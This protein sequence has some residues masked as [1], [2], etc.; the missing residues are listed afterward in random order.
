MNQ[1]KQPTWLSQY[2]KTLRKNMTEAERRLWHHLRSN[3][4]NDA[5]FRRQVPIHHYIADFLCVSAHLV[6]ELDGSQHQQSENRIYDK[7]R[8]LYFESLGYRVLRVSNEEVFNTIVF[9]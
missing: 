4:L 9:T 5:K 3:R 2:A 6:V 8:T 7:K 1:H